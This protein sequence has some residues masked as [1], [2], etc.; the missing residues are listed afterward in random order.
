MDQPEVELHEKGVV[1]KVNTKMHYNGELEHFALMVNRSKHAPL[2]D[3]IP[4]GNASGYLWET[5][6]DEKEIYNVSLLSC[7][8]II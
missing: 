8:Y 2:D 7:S 5:Q 4:S 6:C 3:E 1:L